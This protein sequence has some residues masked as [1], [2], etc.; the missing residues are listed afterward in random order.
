M[1][2]LPQG[3]RI[4]PTCHIAG[5]NGRGNV[6]ALLSS[7]LHCSPAVGRYNSPHLVSMYDSL[8]INNPV[9]KEVYTEAIAKVYHADEEHG[10][11]LSCFRLLTLYVRGGEIDVVL[12]A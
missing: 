3:L 8:A 2:H 7:I 6:S 12:A 10:T 1:G 5:T 9:D 11:E 4:R